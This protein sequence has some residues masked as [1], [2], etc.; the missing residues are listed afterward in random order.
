MRIPQTRATRYNR[1]P[2][3]LWGDPVVLLHQHGQHPV[4]R[5]RGE[6]YEAM[7]PRFSG[8][9]QLTIDFLELGGGC[10]ALLCTPDDRKVLFNVGF[11]DYMYRY[12]QWRYLDALNRFGTHLL[13]RHVVQL[14]TDGER[15]LLARRI[16]PGNDWRISEFEPD[17]AR[18][19]YRKES[20]GSR[21]AWR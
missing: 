1:P 12:L 16:T 14:R 13:R 7:E 20:P 21:T 19:R 17:G 8:T 11:G 6:Q 3:L 18:L 10:G 2:D 9:P 15:A 4:V 5:A